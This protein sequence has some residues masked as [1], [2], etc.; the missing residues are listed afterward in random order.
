M[1]SKKKNEKKIKG[2]TMSSLTM[3]NININNE[4]QPSASARNLLLLDKE[5]ATDGSFE[6]KTYTI[7]DKGTDKL[8][9]LSEKAK[10]T[11]NAIFSEDVKLEEVYYAKYKADYDQ[12]LKKALGDN[13]I[14]ATVL[15]DESLDAKQVVENVLGDTGLVFQ[16]TEGKTQDHYENNRLVY[17]RNKVEVIG[18]W[19]SNCLANFPQ[20]T[21]A[22][23]LI[24]YKPSIFNN[25]NE[26]K[27][28]KI[29]VFYVDGSNYYS[30]TGINSQGEHIDKLYAKDY[31]RQNLKNKLKALLLNDK[32]VSYDA[33]G[34]FKIESVLIDAF[35]S[36][37]QE[38]IVRNINGE[39][40]D[41]EI[42]IP[43]FDSQTDDDKNNRLVRV[44]VNF[45]LAG[46][47]EKITAN[48]IIEN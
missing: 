10:N 18:V 32:R 24:N 12:E 19:V 7:N 44:H 15:L 33:T 35:Q 30:G 2:E 8:D 14:Y 28:D 37:G 45:A 5:T 41:Y 39:K 22:N 23:R 31:I 17:V 36:L 6:T 42:N 34:F 11:L 1:L 4:Y 46:S 40:Y 20:S 25:L 43:D 9:A 16:Q 26:L 13:A 38:G 27:N 3:I 48:I 21:W 29:N 47:V